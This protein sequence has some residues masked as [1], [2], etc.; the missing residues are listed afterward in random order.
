MENGLLLLA[1]AALH[2]SSSE[3]GLRQVIDWMMFV[4]QELDDE[5]WNSCFSEMAERAGLRKL[6]VALTRLCRDHL[7]LP[8]EYRW[9]KEADEQM[10]SDLLDL[11]FERG[12]FGR[13]VP[14]HY[15]V[16]NIT[17]KAKARGTFT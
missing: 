4:H 15:N 1:H 2:L 13:K 9:C 6:A 7:G 12:N 3:L 11:I 5:K 16:E 14:D 8:G 10:V 17:A